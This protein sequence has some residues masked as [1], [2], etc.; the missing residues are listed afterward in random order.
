MVLPHIEQRRTWTI[1]I[2]V[3]NINC[4]SGKTFKVSIS[5]SIRKSKIKI[6]AQYFTNIRKLWENVLM[7]SHVQCVNS[8]F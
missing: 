2:C 1:T 3:P 5:T 7:C 4:L 8:H 6:I